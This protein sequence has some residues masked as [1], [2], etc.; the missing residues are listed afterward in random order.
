MKKMVKSLMAVTM[1]LACSGCSETPEPTTGSLEQS[2]RVDLAEFIPEEK[3]KIDVLDVPTDNIP[4][5]PIELVA[6]SDIPITLTNIPVGSSPQ[7]L[8]DSQWELE[9]QILTNYSL[10]SY[11]IDNP[12]VVLN[13]YGWTPLSALVMFDTAVPAKV[14]VTVLGKD[15][16]SNISHTFDGFK[17]YHELPVLGLYADYV[18]QVEIELK[19][20]D[21]TTITNIIEIVTSAINVDAQIE[22]VSSNLAKSQDGITFLNSTIEQIMGIDSNGEVRWMMDYYTR[23]IL[24]R[25]E[26]GNWLI[27]DADIAGLYEVDLL[28]KIYAN[29]SNYQDINDDVIELP[30]G[31][32]LTTSH[33][34]GAYVKDRILEID[35]D[36]GEIVN[37]IDL[38]NVLDK[39]RFNSQDNSDW[40]HM[41]ALWYD[42]SDDGLIVSGANQGV[43][44]ISY[45]EGELLWA[46]TVARDVDSLGDKVLTPIGEN[47]KPPVGQHA[48]MII[49]DQDDD[50][51]TLD[52]V[53]YDNNR[54]SILEYDNEF[55]GGMYSRMVQYRINEIAMTVEQI[56]SY[57]EDR[58]TEY[59]TI[60]VSDADYLANGNMLGT[61]GNHIVGD[62]ANTGT[63]IEVNRDN[64]EVVFEVDIKFEDKQ[65]IYRAEKLPMYPD[66]WEFALGTT[67]G[68]VKAENNHER[69][70][71]LEV[72]EIALLPD[73]DRVYQKIE[74]IL[75]TDE[76]KI[77][78]YQAAIGVE[79]RGAK[80]Y[81]VFC[82]PTVTK[83]I[84]LTTEPTRIEIT[85]LI[86]ETLSDE[87]DYNSSG[88]TGNIPLEF[89][90]NAL[91]KQQYQLGILT[92]LGDELYYQES[93]YYLT[94]T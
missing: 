41:N 72:T 47:F 46:L 94:V 56:W 48:P 61:F 89:L 7:S 60:N 11:S 31:N 87:V 27:G 32:L 29:Y 84:N 24:R 70:L 83:A 2:V 33:N 13:P 90:K 28:G 8:I 4:I 42:E 30:N 1:I 76:L 54:A 40:F 25:L 21:G 5:E 49:P 9:K 79:S 18:N 73:S 57:G 53:L 62:D 92:E 43:F 74:E 16:F 34:L 58:G 77:E 64:G 78:G 50:P 44:K 63:I 12:Y 66:V 81:L 38:K 71:G 36:T 22:L 37:D 20:E 55:D 93:Q 10:N 68:V 26:N 35:Y 17:T 3:L 19:F 59:Y 67:K 15:E 65:W 82:S 6:G 23:Q 51:H 45:P 88:F 14:S 52:I 80:H 91:P 86:N 75:M 39:N 85:R 69:V